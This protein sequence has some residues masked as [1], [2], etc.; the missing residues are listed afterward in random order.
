LVSPEAYFNAKD[1]RKGRRQL[2]RTDH[3]SSIFA[4]HHSAAP[5]G[6]GI[7]GVNRR[8]YRLERDS[9]KGTVCGA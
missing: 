5:A 8:R 9:L 2:F 6:G 1:K 7:A 3:N 4:G